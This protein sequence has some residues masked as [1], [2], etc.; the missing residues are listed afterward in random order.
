MS[1]ELLTHVLSSHWRLL[2]T[3]AT[4]WLGEASSDRSDKEDAM[5]T[6]T[7]AYHLVNPEPF[8]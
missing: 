4:D 7:P 6:I 5:G 2:R 8:C 3:V 1:F